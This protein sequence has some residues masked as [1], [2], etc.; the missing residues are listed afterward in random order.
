MEMVTSV[1]YHVKSKRGVLFR[2]WAN[3]VLKDY[4]VKGYAVNQRIH[5][6]Q[7]GELRQL[8]GMLGRTLQNQQRNTRLAMA[9][10]VLLPHCSFGS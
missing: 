8:V 3:K 2:K 6:E 1:G 7:I 10:S 9:T 5:S 4:L